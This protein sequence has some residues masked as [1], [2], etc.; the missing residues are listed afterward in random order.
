MLYIFIQ[1]LSDCFSHLFYT[2]VSDIGSVSL[3]VSVSQECLGGRVI[4]ILTVLNVA[5]AV[6]LLL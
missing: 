1:N 4:L 5:L 6:L 3:A 2:F